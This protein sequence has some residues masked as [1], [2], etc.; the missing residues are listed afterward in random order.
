ML[1]YRSRMKQK[2]FCPVSWNNYFS[3]CKKVKVG[4]S[5]F[6]VYTLGDS[7]PL[8]VLLHGGGYSGL[9]WSLFAVR[10]CNI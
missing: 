1:C 6:N 10:K 5:N 8:L 4:E 7:G 2:D 9:T 3:D